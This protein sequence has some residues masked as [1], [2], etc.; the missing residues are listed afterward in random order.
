MDWITHLFLWSLVAVFQVSMVFV[1]ARCFADHVP[2][3]NTACK[4]AKLLFGDRD[5]KGGRKVA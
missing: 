3:V 1:I 5:K 4:A 2:T